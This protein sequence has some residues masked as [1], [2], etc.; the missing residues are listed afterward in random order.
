MGENCKDESDLL[1]K[2]NIIA[3]TNNIFKTPTEDIPQ[4]K[5]FRSAFLLALREEWFSSYEFSADTPISNKKYKHL[6]S[7]H[8]NSFYFI[9][10]QL[11]F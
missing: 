11:D 10:N 6:I 8:K 3:T 2:I 4:K 9:N 7:K 1:D 5:L